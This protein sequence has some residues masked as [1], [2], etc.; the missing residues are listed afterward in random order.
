MRTRSK[1]G[2]SISR[3]VGPM[4]VLVQPDER[5]R[6]RGRHHQLGG[7]AAQSFGDDRV[8]LAIG[9]DRPRHLLEVLA[10]KRHGR[11]ATRNRRVSDRAR[12][13][14]GVAP[15]DR[16]ARRLGR[17]ACDTVARRRNRV[18]VGWRRRGG[19]SRRRRRGLRRRGDDGGAR[20]QEPPWTPSP[21]RYPATAWRRRT[22]RKE[23]CDGR[24]DE[25]G[26]GG[27]PRVPRAPVV[28]RRRRS[29]RA[30]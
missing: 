18:P 11:G 25:R 10:P 17:H 8:S 22:P 13:E 3:G 21:A 5:A 29:S 26:P 20:R 24:F 14:R 2:V 30:S 1:R 4:R 12:P 27:S 28:R 19:R 9:R 7:R 16:R 15:E 6:R 23:R